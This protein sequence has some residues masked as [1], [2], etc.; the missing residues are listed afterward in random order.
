M[1]RR[2]GDEE[3]KEEEYEGELREEAA[4]GSGD[5]RLERGREEDERG[6]E[7]VPQR[8]VEE[9]QRASA[10]STGHTGRNAARHT[11]LALI[12]AP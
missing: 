4:E 5:K 3:K 2:G 1:E 7:G 12:T 9:N 11:R 6:R 10:L 8:E